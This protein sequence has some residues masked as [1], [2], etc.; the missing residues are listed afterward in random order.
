MRSVG[1]PTYLPPEGLDIIQAFE[2]LAPCV[3]CR[4]LPAEHPFDLMCPPELEEPEAS[5]EHLPPTMTSFSGNFTSGNYLNSVISYSPG[6][7]G[8]ISTVPSTRFFRMRRGSDRRSFQDESH[9]VGRPRRRRT[10]DRRRCD[11]RGNEGGIGV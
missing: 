1:Y 5:V 4:R 7:Q 11:V 3:R 6:N 2:R 9:D 8:R 10:G